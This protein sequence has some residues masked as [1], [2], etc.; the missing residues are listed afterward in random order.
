M[1][2][3]FLGEAH[4]DDDIARLLGDCGVPFRRFETDAALAE[5]VA[6]RLAARQV[7]GWFRGRFEWG[8]RALG[9]RSILADARDPAARERVNAKVKQRETFRPLAPA[10]LADEA[11]R[12]FDVPPGW[13]DRLAPFMC[14]VVGVRP[15]GRT[16]LPSVVHVDGTARVQRID[17]PDNPVFHDLVEAFR[18]A[19][20][21]GVVLNTSLNLK[22]EPPCASPA[23]ALA[24]WARSGLDFLALERC[25]VERAAA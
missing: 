20:G 25:L 21:V 24:L 8:P 19:T 16:V 6:A 14:G 4:G 15:E 17:R 1:R 7:G 18:R 10:V 9:A 11:H 13:S 5:A 12:W 22:G 23:E 2:N 3:V